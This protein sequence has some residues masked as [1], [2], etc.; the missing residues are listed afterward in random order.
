M[1][2]E[3]ANEMQNEM[4]VRRKRGKRGKRG[5]SWAHLL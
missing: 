2:A 5:E 3:I 1:F 4:G